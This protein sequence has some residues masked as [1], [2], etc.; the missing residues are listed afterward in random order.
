MN[1]FT[2]KIWD[3]LKETWKKDTISFEKLFT[4]H[5]PDIEK[6]WISGTLNLVSLNETALIATIS[7]NCKVKEFCE[8]CGNKFEREINVSNY[9]AKF[10]IP[11]EENYDDNS[12]EIEELFPINEKTLTI[13]IEELII[14]SIW[15]EEPIT[16][17]CPKCKTQIDTDNEMDD[18]N[19]FESKSN[20]IFS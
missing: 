16:K 4:E 13:D 9:S 3:L 2:I 18:T 15:I 19:Y 5:Y 17:K 1:K 20:I 6:S 14:N 10:I 12:D 8:R 11:N 7:L